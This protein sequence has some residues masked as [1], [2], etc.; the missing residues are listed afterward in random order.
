MVGELCPF[1][2]QPPPP[3]QHTSLTLIYKVQRRVF[4]FLRAFLY[5][6][7]VVAVNTVKSLYVLVFIVFAASNIKQRARFRPTHKTLRKLSNFSA[8][9][10]HYLLRNSI[11]WGIFSLMR[12]SNNEKTA[13]YCVRSLPL[14]FLSLC[15][16]CPS[17]A[18]LIMP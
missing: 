9:A 14:V 15:V 12:N 11:E 10:Y 1:R 13:S 2:V 6:V 3:I 4:C 17:Q 16:H 7:L 8:F 5:E 18:F